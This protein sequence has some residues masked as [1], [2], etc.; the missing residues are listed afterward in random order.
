[1]RPPFRSGGALHWN[2][3]VVSRLLASDPGRPLRVGIDG[4]SAA[5]KTTLAD[6]LATTLRTATTRPVIRAEL[7]NFMIVVD[8]PD[9]PPYD[10]AENF[11]TSAWDLAAIRRHLLEPLGPAGNRRYR[12]AADAD[13]RLA[14]PGTILIADGVFLQRP[15]LDPHWDLRIYLD[16]SPAA[17]L[18]R[19]VDRD[20]HWMGGAAAAERRFRTRYR[21][22][23]ERYFAAVRPDERADLVIPAGG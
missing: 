9:A 1:M 12:S 8:D 11:F 2:N 4:R 19:A 22:A 5:G 13:E 23:E 18:R 15:E 20:R 6:A 7:D 16:I 3:K 14:G 17:S 10:S 21:P